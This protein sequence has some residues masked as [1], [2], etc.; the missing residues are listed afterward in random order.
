M[1]VVKLKELITNNQS[2]ITIQQMKKYIFS[3]FLFAISFS[4][5]AQQEFGTHFMSTTPQS[6]FTNP[7]AF[8]DYKVTV[9][10]PSV[11]AGFYNTAFAPDD[12]FTKNGSTLE[13]SVT[14]ALDQ[15]GDRNNMTLNTSLET[16]G[17]SIQTKKFRFS[18]N[19]GLK[20]NAGLNFPKEML[21][22][23][24][25]GNAQ[26]IDETINIAPRVNLMAYQE[27]G[28]GVGYKVSENL[29]LGTR[30][31]YL[32]GAG[33]FYTS[34]SVIAVH[35]DPDY[36]ALTAETDYLIHT[37]GIPE[38]DLNNG[39][40]FDFDFSPQL[41]S[42]NRG[43]AFDL[44]ANLSGGDKINIQT[45]ILNLG[46]ITW[47]DQ[48]NNYWSQGSI[49]FDGLDL[50]EMLDEGE[51]DT[52]E[53]IDSIGQTFEFQHAQSRFS[54]SLPGQFYLS[55]TYEVIPNLKVGALFLAEGFQTT[56]TRA[57]GVNAQKDFGRWGAV[58][59]N[60]VV[61]EGGVHNFGVNGTVNLGPVQIFAMTDNL[62]PLFNPMKTQNTNV[63]FGINLVFG[64]VKDK[65]VTEEVSEELK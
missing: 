5:Q 37:A 48:V 17:F 64:R 42:E 30:V 62:I 9:S 16:I 25:G 19:H 50:Q 60:Y 58:G 26:F 57:F 43:F 44:G 51:L 24:W 39:D 38:A 7:A 14:D 46:K 52:E 49:E 28:F 18:F 45:S 20:I 8:G 53:L 10:L 22:F 21:Q 61:Q 2:P 1:F 36:Y 6:F 34:N 32:V 4:A 11:Y 65:E 63:R 13:L 3:L 12:I 56:M 33:A 54:S 55:G 47:K 59:A 41:S 35:T 23:A 15:L 40:F 29:S 27:F 31:K